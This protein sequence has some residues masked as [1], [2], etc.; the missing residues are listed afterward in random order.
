MQVTIGIVLM[1][2]IFESFPQINEYIQFNLQVNFAMSL[3][4]NWN[5]WERVAI[6]GWDSDRMKNP[7]AK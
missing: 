2:E 6:L 5:H 3:G 4:T 1:W 7:V